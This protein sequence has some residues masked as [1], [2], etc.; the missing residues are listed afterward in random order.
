LTLQLVFELAPSPAKFGLMGSP[1]GNCFCVVREKRGA[2]HFQAV[3]E[4][5]HQ[6]QA[7]FDEL[8]ELGERGVHF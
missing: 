2:A 8:A 7:L 3:A 4:V 1:A 5:V 6:Q